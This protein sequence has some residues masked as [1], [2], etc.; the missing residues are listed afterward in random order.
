MAI[1]DYELTGRAARILREVPEP[2]WRAVERRVIAAVRATPRGGWPLDVEDPNPGALG[3]IRVS[4]LVLSTLLS[5]ELAGDPDYVVTGIDVTSEGSVLL[6]IS[7]QLSGRYLSELPSVT[8][9]ITGRC[10][11]VLAN[12][13][14][15][16][17]DVA[18]TVTVIDVHR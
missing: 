3:T 7:I 6:G 2:G 5:R 15:R 11:A 10:E 12:V 18:I 14:G 4:D 16:T 1:G 9:R 8:D 13:L 17:A